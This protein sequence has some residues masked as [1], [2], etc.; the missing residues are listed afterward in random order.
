MTFSPSV[1]GGSVMMRRRPLMGQ[2]R[3]H[4]RR[5]RRGRGIWDDIKSGIG[6][7]A[8]HVL[9]VLKDVGISLLK[10]KFGLARRR[11]RSRMGR[12]I[13]SPYSGSYSVGMRRHRRRRLGRSRP[14]SHMIMG[15]RRR[16]RRVGMRRVRR[17]RVGRRRHRL[18]GRGPFGS[19]LG[20]VV[21][22]LGHL[23]PF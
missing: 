16:R 10:K 12:S 8:G 9:P 6:S 1:W 23:L 13:L 17:T 18:R 14:H 19:I 15:L 3:S 22:S 2:R 7:V 4:L 20:H 21:G 5:S 11:R